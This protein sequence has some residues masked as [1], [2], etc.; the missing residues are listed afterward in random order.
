MQ[1]NNIDFTKVISAPPADSDSSNVNAAE[2]NKILE[3]KI[4]DNEKAMEEVSKQLADSQSLNESDKKSQSELEIK[5]KETQEHYVKS[6]KKLL[7]LTKE[8]A[9]LDVLYAETKV[10]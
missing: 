6:E 3:A 1:E 5:F 7:E 9:D 8:K 2:L 10:C 4:A